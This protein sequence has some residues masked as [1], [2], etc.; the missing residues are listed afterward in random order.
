MK[1][2]VDGVRLKSGAAETPAIAAHRE[3]AG[4]VP[5][6]V[7]ARGIEHDF[8]E[9]TRKPTNSVWKRLLGKS[10]LRFLDLCGMSVRDFDHAISEVFRRGWIEEKAVSGA[11]SL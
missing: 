1:K 3:F 7:A 6:V 11:C 4:L 10:E 8:F 9:A 5:S 2:P